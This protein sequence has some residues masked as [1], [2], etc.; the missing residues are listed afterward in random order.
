[1][2]RVY[3]VLII[4]GGPAGLSAALTLARGGR[5]VLIFDHHKP[6]NARALHMQNFPSH[7]GLPPAEFKKLIMTDLKEY[8]SVEF[9]NAQVDE[10]SKTENGFS[11]RASGGEFLGRKILLAHGMKDQMLPIK[12]FS[13]LWGRSIFQCPYCHGHEY[14]GMPMALL[15]GSAMASH[16]LPILKGLTDDLILLSQG[17]EIENADKILSNGIQIFG[18]KILE[19]QG[20]EGKLENIVFESGKSLERRILFLKVPQTLS[21]DV[22]IKLGCAVSELGFYMVDE[23]AKT[24]I[25]GVFAA[26][27]IVSMRQSVLMA[28]SS[29]QAAGASLNYELLAEDFNS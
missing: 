8:S 28:C 14:R 20:S 26:G 1:M 21:T 9:E 19:L 4:G 25:P 3:D 5:R 6:R 12:G 16:M 22:G 13:E 18:D 29:G 15:A 2:K 10:L 27:D 17:E 11:I 23:M 7:D 24:T